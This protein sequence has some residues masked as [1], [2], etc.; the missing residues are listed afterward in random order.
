M[1]LTTPP[2][3][4]LIG[5]YLKKV[6]GSNHFIW[7]MDVYPDIAVDLN[8]LDENSIVTRVCRTLANFS[9]HEA[10]GVMVLGECMRERLLGH[11]IPIHKIHITENWADGKVIQPVAHCLEDR[12]TILYSGN[13]GLAHDVETFSQAMLELRADPHFYF[14]FAGGGFHHGRLADWCAENGIVNASFRCYCNLSDLGK[15]L[16][17]GDVGLVTQK[18]SCSGSVVPSKVYGLMAAGRPILYIGPKKST[19]SNI[20]NASTAV[21]KSTA[22]MLPA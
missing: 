6:R 7:E 19:P 12:L 17:E 2:L 20:V 10:D 8:V 5:T 3:L 11:G 13:L 9:R 4:S 16:G 22:G 1:T 15:S 14:V 18:A 21:G